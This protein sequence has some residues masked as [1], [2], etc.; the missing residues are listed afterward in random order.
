MYIKTRTV[1]MLPTRESLQIQKYTV[2]ESEGMGKGVP[3][4]GNQKKVG[5]SILMSDKIDFKTNTVIR[6]K[7]GYYIL[8]KRSILEEYIAIVNIYTPN[9]GVPRFIKPTL[10]DIKWGIDSSTIIASH[11]HQWIDHPDKK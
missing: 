5:V 7:G 10:T 6:D 11:L 2:T 8:I 3:W 9:I 1:Y 4:T